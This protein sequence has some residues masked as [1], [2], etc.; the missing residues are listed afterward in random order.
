MKLTRILAISSATLMFTLASARADMICETPVKTSGG[1]LRG[2]TDEGTCVWRGVPYASPPVAD[3]RWKAPRKPEA[4]QGVREA[5]EFPSACTQY[6]GLMATMDCSEIGSLMGSED[7]LYL[8]IWRP[9]SEAKKLPVLFW[10]HGGAN[11]VGQSNMSLYYGAHFA[12]GADMIFVS[13]NYRLG[14]MGWLTSPLLRTGD[15]LDDSGDYGTLDIIQALKWVHENIEAFGGDPGDV[16]VAGESAGGIN[17]FTLLASP[18]ASG[19]FQR[20][21]AESGAPMSNRAGKG[22]AKGRTARPR[23][24]G[25]GPHGLGCGRREKSSVRKRKGLGRFLPPLQDRR[26]DLWAIQARLNGQP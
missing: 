6:A 7:C 18:L 12:R 1:L 25:Q 3:L 22:R 19:L 11:A 17:V 13:I 9:K 5:K 21:I 24:N 10:I 15:K 8:N 2:T 23:P 26:G 16:T 14:P 20:A 4:W